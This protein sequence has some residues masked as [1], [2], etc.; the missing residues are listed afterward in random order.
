MVMARDGKSCRCWQCDV[1]FEKEVSSSSALV[2]LMNSYICTR[3]AWLQNNPQ[4][5]VKIWPGQAGGRGRRGRGGKKEAMEAGKLF[6]RFAARD[7]PDWKHEMQD[8]KLCFLK[9]ASQWEPLI[10][11]PCSYLLSH[12]HFFWLESIRFLWQKAFWLVYQY[13]LLKLCGGISKK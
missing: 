11:L 5:V 7:S 8:R 13:H 4:N 6:A 2:W 1:R 10:F 3:T 12:E 9:W